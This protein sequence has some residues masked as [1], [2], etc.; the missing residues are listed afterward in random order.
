M[1]EAW[2]RGVGVLGAGPEGTALPALS[3][4][5]LRIAAPGLPRWPGNDSSWQ[6]AARSAEPET[7]GGRA[8]RM[9]GL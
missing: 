7:G 2:P 3:A 6:R 1:S 4:D 5:I 9:K 8:G